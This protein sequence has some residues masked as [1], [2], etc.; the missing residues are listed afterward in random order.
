MSRQAKPDL[1]AGPR[2]PASEPEFGQCLD[3][4]G[5]SFSQGR[6]HALDETGIIG[7]ASI[8]PRPSGRR[9]SCVQPPQDY[10]KTLI[11][12]AKSIRYRVLPDAAVL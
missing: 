3:A 2:K 11:Y 8:L 6:A 4:I 9:R 7:T 12:F 5:D 10:A 1:A